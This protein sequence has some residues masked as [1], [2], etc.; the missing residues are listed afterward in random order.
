MRSPLAFAFAL[1]S[2]LAASCSSDRGWQRYDVEPI[3]SLGPLEFDYAGEISSTGLPEPAEFP[4]KTD[5]V[6]GADSIEVRV[7]LLTLEREAAVALLGPE[8]AAMQARRVQRSAGEGLLGTLETIPI[9]EQRYTHELRLPRGGRAEAMSSNVVSFVESFELQVMGNHSIADPR[10]GTVRDG[11]LLTVTT[12]EGEVGAPGEYEL[13]LHL[14][15]LQRPI[16]ETDSRLP[17][18][19]TSIT[20]QTPVFTSQSLHV[21]AST[22]TNESCLLGPIPSHEDGRVLLVLVTADVVPTELPAA[23]PEGDSAK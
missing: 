14:C 23:L 4:S 2:L 19:S 12:D 8:G 6:A 17:G 15:E 7:K 16:A 5:D 22:S 20:V 11:M 10:I 9:L 18:I 3:E 13:A 1:S 21:R